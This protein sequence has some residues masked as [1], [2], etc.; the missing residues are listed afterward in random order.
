MGVLVEELEL[1]AEQVAV[2]VGADIAHDVLAQPAA[3]VGLQIAHAGMGHQQHQQQQEHKV[4][5][6]HVALLNAD[7]DHALNQKGPQ[8]AQHRRGNGEH[9]EADEHAPVGAHVA[10]QTA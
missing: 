5:P 6:L 3:V 4:Q 7:I 10:Q 1:E 2:E 8:R 9:D